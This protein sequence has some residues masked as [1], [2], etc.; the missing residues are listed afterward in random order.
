MF[1]AT[2]DATDEA[3]TATY[4]TAPSPGASRGDSF[5]IRVH[6]LPMRVG[7]GP[8]VAHRMGATT[9]KLSAVPFPESTR[10]LT[11]LWNGGGQVAITCRGTR[12]D[13]CARLNAR[14][15]G[16]SVTAGIRRLGGMADPSERRQLLAQAAAFTLERTGT[17]E[18]ALEIALNNEPTAV[19]NQQTAV[20]P[21]ILPLCLKPRLQRHELVLAIVGLVPPLVA[22]MAARSVCPDSYVA[23][24]TGAGILQLPATLADVPLIDNACLLALWH[25]AF[26]HV[27]TSCRDAGPG[28]H[29][30]LYSA[31]DAPFRFET[32]DTGELRLAMDRLGVYWA[33]AP[34]S[35]AS[36][37]VGREGVR[38][39]ARDYG[40]LQTLLLAGFLAPALCSRLDDAR[41][42]LLRGAQQGRVRDDEGP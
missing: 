25:E 1:A 2:M 31:F 13:F 30:R 12:A 20:G 36:F 18:R 27:L 9:I 37:M 34:K 24:M 22:A 8:D 3:V 6:Q 15:V 42:T 29:R 33:P 32:A 17:L 23:R 5:A 14:A 19:A 11:R 39:A 40:L 41:R 16:A 21:L 35:R 10:F 28:H 38:V 7:A 4:W 26:V